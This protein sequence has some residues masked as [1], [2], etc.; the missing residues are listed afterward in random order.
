[1]CGKGEDARLTVC[2]DV[3]VCVVN[4]LRSGNFAV[5][6]F[7]LA[8]AVTW[9]TCAYY[10]NKKVKEMNEL[11]KILN[12]KSAVQAASARA[13]AGAAALDQEPDSS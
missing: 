5:G 1:M 11:V 6:G 12:R 2:G 3:C 8:S 9:H 10:H 13:T 7:M 4:G